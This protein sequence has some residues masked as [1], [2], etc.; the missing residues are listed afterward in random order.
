MP[1]LALIDDDLANF[2]FSQLFSV[3]DSEGHDKL[4]AN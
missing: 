2:H 3:K 4:N 1:L